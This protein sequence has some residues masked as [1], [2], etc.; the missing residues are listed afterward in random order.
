M[1]N[2][3]GWDMESTKG[4]S[5][6]VTETEKISGSREPFQ[7]LVYNMKG[8]YQWLTEASPE[9]VA[10]YHIAMSRFM[11]EGLSSVDDGNAYDFLMGIPRRNLKVRHQK[12]DFDDLDD[13][14][15]YMLAVDYGF[16]PELHSSGLIYN[17]YRG[18]WETDSKVASRRLWSMAS[19]KVKLAFEDNKGKLRV[20]FESLLS[21]TGLKLGGLI[22]RIRKRKKI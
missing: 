3:N 4:Q 22:Q 20:F 9:E 17:K 5:E 13:D 19:K 16:Q 12:I 15:L 10:R 11:N 21:G 6:Q 14:Q 7:G 2:I 18:R 8:I 1:G